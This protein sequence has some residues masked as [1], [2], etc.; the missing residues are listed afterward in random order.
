MENSVSNNFLSTFVDTINIFDCRLSSVCMLGNF[1]CYC[2]ALLTFFFKI[3]IF[4][5]L[6]QCQMVWNQIR[7]DIL[8]V[9]ILAQLFAKVISRRQ[10]VE[11]SKDTVKY[12]SHK[13]TYLLLRLIFYEKVCVTG[14]MRTINNFLHNDS[15][16]CKK[17]KY[18]HQLF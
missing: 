16:T 15:R 6:S 7:N 11:N 17:G 18:W 10:K 4:K 1:L 14:L 13:H 2:L 8:S 12:S 9:V 5:A 3:K